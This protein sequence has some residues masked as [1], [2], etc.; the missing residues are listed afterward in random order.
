MIKREHKEYVRKYLKNL[1]SYQP[2]VSGMSIEYD[3]D[4]EWSDEERVLI[5]L[6]K[7]MLVVRM[8]YTTNLHRVVAKALL[9]ISPYAVSQYLEPIFGST[10]A[11]LLSITVA[12]D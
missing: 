9:M 12:R 11:Q 10:L 1:V 7:G 4:M 2:S 3:I 8:P 5:D 6:E